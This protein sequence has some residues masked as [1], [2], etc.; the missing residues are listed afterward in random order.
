MFPTDKDYDLVHVTGQ[1]KKLSQH[2]TGQYLLVEVSATFCGACIQTVQ[3]L[4]HDS[5][6]DQYFSN[7]KCQKALFIDGDGAGSSETSS[8]ILNNWHQR[9]GLSASGRMGSVSFSAQQ[10]GQ[11]VPSTRVASSF[12]RSVTTIPAFFIIDRTGN[13]VTQV[14]NSLPSS[15]LAQLCR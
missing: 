8:V 11:R 2:F 7:G 5:S 1:K 4:E 12:G 6:I 3:S 13:A 14:T 10:N 15:Q 9:T